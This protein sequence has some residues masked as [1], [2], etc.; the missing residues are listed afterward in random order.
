MKYKKIYLYGGPG[1]GKTTTGLILAN[2]FGYKLISLDAI[3]Y[4][5]GK[6]ISEKLMLEELTSLISHEP[7]WIVDGSCIGW[8]DILFKTADLVVIFE[9]PF[10]VALARIIRRFI[11]QTSFSFNST[12]KLCLKTLPAYYTKYVVEY[13]YKAGAKEIIKYDGK[14]INKLISIL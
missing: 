14:S 11:K 12:L 10:I 4:K 5:E 8:S 9:T 13:P 1:F 6:K 3:M 2:K 7:C